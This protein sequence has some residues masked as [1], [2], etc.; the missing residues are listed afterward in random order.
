MTRP[1]TP[2]LK[3]LKARGL[4]D[5]TALATLGQVIA[6]NPAYR[7]KW[8]TPAPHITDETRKQVAEQLKTSE[9]LRQAVRE[10]GYDADSLAAIERRRG[11]TLKS[12]E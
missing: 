11:V 3:F 12:E 6:E 8:S 2:L 1:P 10:L 7:N 4:I 9:R 5:D